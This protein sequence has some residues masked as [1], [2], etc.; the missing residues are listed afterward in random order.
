MIRLLGLNR[1]EGLTRLLRL[2]IRLSRHQFHLV[3]EARRRP[4]SNTVPPLVACSLQGRPGSPGRLIFLTCDGG[5]SSGPASASL[6]ARPDAASFCRTDLIPARSSGA[7]TSPNPSSYRSNQ[8][9][10]CWV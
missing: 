7:A 6:T 2:A 9:K 4:S 1:H 3:V 10:P 8:G 5:I